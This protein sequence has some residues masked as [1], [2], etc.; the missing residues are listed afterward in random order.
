MTMYMMGC[1]IRGLFWDQRLTMSRGK[2]SELRYMNGICCN[3]GFW[4]ELNRGG[5]QI[6]HEC[7]W[8][9]SMHK[10]QTK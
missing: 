8:Y 9:C 5:K 2:K 3:K 4:E 1:F 6:Y 10:P 7:E